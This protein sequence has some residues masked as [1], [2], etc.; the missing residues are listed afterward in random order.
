MKLVYLITNMPTNTTATETI[1]RYYTLGISASL[2]TSYFLMDLISG[3][4]QQ[5]SQKIT[6]IKNNYSQKHPSIITM[7][8]HD[9]I[10]LD[11]K[12]EAIR[13]VLDNK[14]ALLNAI[15]ESEVWNVIQPW[16]TR[17]NEIFHTVS[18][19]IAGLSSE[20]VSKALLNYYTEQ[21]DINSED[22][23]VRAEEYYRLRE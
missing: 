17:F 11:L 5:T 16:V 20:E 2:S 9:D 6:Q 18:N 10:A 1:K 7:E 19:A 23:K 3:V 15:K 4:D 22:A 13:T 21:P 8:T 12:I 14:L